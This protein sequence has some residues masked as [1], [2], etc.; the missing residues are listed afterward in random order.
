MFTSILNIATETLS[1]TDA[2]ICMG[3]A[4]L[5]GILISLTYMSGKT[6][7]K[8]FAVTLVVLPVLVQVV[9]MMVNG[10]LGTGVA[11]VGAFS[12]VRFRSLPGTSRDICFVFFAMATGLSTGMGYIS[13]S[14][15]TTVIICAIFFALFRSKFAEAGEGERKL[16]ITI[17]ENLDYTSI[18]DDLF[19]KYT[20]DAE[21]TKVK[22]TNLG[23][24]FELNYK[25]ILKNLYEEK[26]F[27]D[28]I[29]CRNGNLTI[30]SSRNSENQEEL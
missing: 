4:L 13:F 19:E 23:S 16:R 25:I 27:L 24:M 29:R 11:I 18:F 12:L 1:V 10:N 22:T 3:T 21:L 2:L 14:V 30:I 28:A 6:Y 20:D 17:P 7:T 15:I 8:N 5:L 26:A 9:I